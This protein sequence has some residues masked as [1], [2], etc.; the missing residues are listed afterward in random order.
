[1]VGRE[2]GVDGLSR[3]IASLDD[4]EASAG[5][6]V[7]DDLGDGLA[8]VGPPVAVVEEFVE[9]GLGTEVA[10]QVSVSDELGDLSSRGWA[11]LST[12]LELDSERGWRERREYSRDS[13]VR[14]YRGRRLWRRRRRCR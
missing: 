4:D 12:L 2:R 11:F 8:H 6:A 9:D 14:W 7:L 5:I 13:R 1:M 3:V 10:Q